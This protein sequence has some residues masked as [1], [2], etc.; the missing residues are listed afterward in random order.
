MNKKDKTIALLESMIDNV[1]NGD[2]F[3]NE[4]IDIIK[5]INVINK[6]RTFGTSV[7][8]ETRDI[9]LSAF[10]RLLGYKQSPIVRDE[11]KVIFGFLDCEDREQREKDVLCYYNNIGLFQTYVDLWRNLK[12]M[13][14]N[15]K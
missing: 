7:I 10:L 3:N 14:H 5:L 15:Y 2:S 1:K 13:L 4:C 8:F 12:S 6:K 9:N 11:S